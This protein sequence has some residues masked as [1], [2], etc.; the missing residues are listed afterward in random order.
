ME[1]ESPRSPVPDFEDL[2]SRQHLGF[3]VEGLE[4]QGPLGV[5]GILVCWDPHWG[6]VLMKHLYG[7]AQVTSV[8]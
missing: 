1:P 2:D 7:C 3:R 8:Q 4:F 5:L 6:P